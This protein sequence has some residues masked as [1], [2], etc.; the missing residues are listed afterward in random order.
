MAAHRQ[1]VHQARPPPMPSTPV[2]PPLSSSSTALRTPAFAHQ[3]PSSLPQHS[4]TRFGGL[5]A[6]QVDKISSAI[7]SVRNPSRREPPQVSNDPQPVRHP[8]LARLKGTTTALKP[9]NGCFS[10]APLNSRLPYFSPRKYSSK[11]VPAP[12][13][14]PRGPF[15]LGSDEEADVEKT[16]EF[17]DNLRSAGNQK[18]QYAKDLE[19]RQRETLKEIDV[20]WQEAL[21][22][23]DL[24]FVLMGIEGNFIEFDPNYSPDDPFERLQGAH[25]VVD[26]DLDPSLRELVGRI[27][28][29]ASYYTSIDAFVE[30]HSHLDYG[31]V[32]H[33]LC[34]AI[35]DVLKRYVTLI[36]QLEHQYNTSPEFTLQRFWF[37]VHDMLHLLKLLHSLTTELVSIYSPNIPSSD[38]DSADD[39]ELDDDSEQD[40]ALKAVLKE[41]NS[42]GRRKAAKAGMT[43]ESNIE[44]MV[45]KGGE[46]LAVLE[47]RVM[48][49]LGDPVASELYSDLLLKASQPYCKMLIQW[50]TQGILADPYE[51]FIIKESK[52][53]TRGTLDM[54]FTDEYW[55]RK[56]VLRNRSPAASASVTLSTPHASQSTRHRRLDSGHAVWRR[57]S[58]VAGG[59]VLPRFLEVWEVKILLA[60]K[61]VNVMRECG[62][63]TNDVNFHEASDDL[64]QF[65]FPT[66]KNPSALITM[67]N[68]AF[69]ELIDRAYISAN[70]SLL[71]LLMKSEDLLGRLQSLKH[72]FFLSQGDSFTTFLDTANHEL[73]KKLKHVNV[74]RLQNQFDLAIRNPSSS[75]SSDPYKEDVKVTMATTSLTDWLLRIVGVTGA[76]DGGQ[77]TSA[78]RQHGFLT[79]EGQH[80]SHTESAMGVAITASESGEVIDAVG[81]GLAKLAASS[82]S[83]SDA[84]TT[85]SS[86]TRKDALTGIDALQL[87]YTVRFP[88]SLVISRKTIL[89][90]QLIF[91]YLLHLK[92]LEQSLTLSWTDHIKSSAW[93]SSTKSY[94]RLECWKRRI[95]N[96]R[97]KMLSFVQS[98]YNFI[99]FEVLEKNYRKLQLKLK[100]V[101]TVDGLLREHVDFLDTCLK[102]CML[103]NSKLLKIHQKLTTACSMFASYT[104]HF[105]KSAST[106]NLAFDNSEGNWE[107]IP[108]DIQNKISMAELALNKFEQNF[109]HHSKVHVDMVTYFASSE[110]LAL[111]ALAVRLTNV[112]STH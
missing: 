111:L 20:E 70:R 88:L 16:H 63:E 83:A 5:S 33:A 28:P 107:A 96:L 31:L 45:V 40:E 81:A 87:D 2:L 95:F 60:G 22:I 44:G 75:S 41:Y 94:P 19:R 69:F 80:A 93:R 92:H 59:A 18:Y 74:S 21:I 112:R 3:T 64:M 53:I 15:D 17:L 4:A 14:C 48:N 11:I 76:I 1:R 72:H 7:A 8:V 50:V 109:N 105:T 43:P 66:K 61:Y 56:Y 67:N 49:T 62:V 46:V 34:A 26:N 51:E 10:G 9:P 104:S 39:P 27:L 36:V 47:D 91:R 106:F 86:E 55:E 29:L 85:I 108:N 13:H 37:Y 71:N 38:E 98:L 103:T 52:S 24:L 54:D 79:G 32:N 12:Q 97:A 78:T 77:S 82:H 23:E 101:D 99:C 57:E 58:G 100:Q 90:Y 68:E 73:A 65:K 110:N 89:R 42:G 30:A 25:F 6:K 35:R 102:E 84:A